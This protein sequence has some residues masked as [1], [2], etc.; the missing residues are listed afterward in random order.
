[1]NPL[2][3]LL[4]ES[5]PV[6]T[7]ALLAGAGG[8]LAGVAL[9]AMIHLELARDRPSGPA[10][11]G[12][13][14]GLVVVASLSRF[15]ARSATVRLGQGTI[16][17]LTARIAR[18][19]LALPLEAFEATD[20]SALLTVLT[21]DTG[22][23]AAALV[24][25]PMLAING[26][27]VLAGLAYIGWM[28]PAV[29]VL[30]LIFAA[31]AV[32]IDRALMFRGMGHLRAARA[33][34]EVLVGH[35]R[36]LLDGFRELKG[37]RGRREAFLTDGLEPAAEAV[38]DRATTGLTIF[39]AAES[40]SQAAFFGLL[41]TLLFVGPGW[42]SLDRAT[43]VGCVL[44]ILYVMT[45][46]DVILT[47]VPALGRARASLLKIEAVV[48]LL[49]ATGRDGSAEPRPPRLAPLRDAIRL[50]GVTYEYRDA[51]GAGFRLG[52]IDLALRPGEIVILAGGNGSGKTTLVKLVAGLYSPRTGSIS[53]DGREVSEADRESYRQR[54][55][56]VFA[57]GHLFPRLHGLDR[58]GLDAEASALLDRL[59]LGR[60]T[61]V[62]GGAFSTVELSQ[63]QRRRLALLTALLEDREV[64]ILD[65]WAANQDRRFKA[66]YYDQILPELRASGKAVLVVSHDEDAFDAAD[67]VLTLRDGRLVEENA[68]DI[69]REPAPL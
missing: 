5:R 15:A 56:T 1:M 25:L 49:E 30:G 3:G 55:S 6:L 57:D 59:G 37:H 47:W 19:I 14:A 33:G 65:E 32:V 53:V 63:G 23:L 45:P 2:S 58:P 16:A 44:V 38:R 67:R 20:A 52:P 43:L 10:M 7:M 21:E 46:L 28:S 8:G 18:T 69:A 42:A 66:E 13:F 48:G 68:A 54:V 41:G 26:P 60:K 64:I 39:A 34:Q 61:R 24:G 9:I 35:V 62:N 27:I 29:L 17:R 51:D 40:W 31:G 22:T 4:R 12:L 11:A 50:D 36:G